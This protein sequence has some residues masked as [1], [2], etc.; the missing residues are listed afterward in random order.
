MEIHCP[1]CRFDGE[2]EEATNVGSQVLVVT[3]L[4]CLSFAFW[5]LFI[6]TSAIVCVFLLSDKKWIC[7]QCEWEY[8]VPLSQYR[9]RQAKES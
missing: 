6:M 4:F 8:P 7:P 2:G 1:N 5:P 9:G 3:I